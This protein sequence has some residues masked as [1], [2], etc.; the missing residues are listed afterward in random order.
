MINQKEKKKKFNLSL[1]IGVWLNSV[2]EMCGFTLKLG[3]RG[4]TS[5]VAHSPLLGCAGTA[6]GNTGWLW[7]E[8]LWKI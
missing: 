4:K 2:L 3:R 1:Q 8:N 5:V 6:G 7:W